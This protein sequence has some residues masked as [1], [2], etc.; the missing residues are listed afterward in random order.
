M[1]L[2]LVLGQPIYSALRI[3]G[4]LVVCLISSS[5]VVVSIVVVS[6]VSRVVIVVVIIVVPSVSAIVVVA[7]VIVLLVVAILLVRVPRLLLGVDRLV[8]PR[9]WWWSGPLG[10]PRWRSI[11]GLR[12]SCLLLT[13]ISGEVASLSAVVAISELRSVPIS[14]RS[15]RIGVWLL[16]PRLLWLSTLVTRWW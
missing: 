13:A 2:G 16:V 3:C 5:T 1:I 7:L 15:L 11:H 8:V 6:A 9:W 10:C 14:L 4:L 12:Y